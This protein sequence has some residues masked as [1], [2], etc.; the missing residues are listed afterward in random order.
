[1]SLLCSIVKKP[2]NGSLRSVICSFTSSDVLDFYEFFYELHQESF[3][4]HQGVLD[5]EDDGPFLNS[6]HRSPS[7]PVGLGSM[8]C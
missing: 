5:E 6:A 3:H 1:M 4:C 7:N 8:R 2:H